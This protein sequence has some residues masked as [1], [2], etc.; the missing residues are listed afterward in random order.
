MCICDLKEIRKYVRSEKTW[1]VAGTINFDFAIHKFKI[2][3]N[4][5]I[6][7]I[8]GQIEESLLLTDIKGITLQNYL[9]K[10]FSF[11]MLRAIQFINYNSC[12]I[13]Q[14]GISNEGIELDTKDFSFKHINII[15]NDRFLSSKELINIYDRYG[16]DY[17]GEVFKTNHIIGFRN[18]N[19]FIWLEYKYQGNTYVALRQHGV[20]K[21]LKYD[22]DNNFMVTSLVFSES[23]DSFILFEYPENDNLN[24]ILHEFLPIGTS[25]W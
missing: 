12:I 8:T 23:Y 18:I 6:I 2:I 20:W 16:I 7:F 9:K 1:N 24:L 22:R 14:L 3:S 11:L 15:E 25:S 5:Y 21:R 13:F 17:L 19:D 10:E 4:E